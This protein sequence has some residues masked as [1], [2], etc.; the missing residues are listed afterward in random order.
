MEIVI[1]LKSYLSDLEEIESTKPPNE[2]R[3]VPTLTELADFAG[4]DVS[5]LSRSAANQRDNVNRKLYGKIIA[6]LRRRGF[7][8]DVGDVLR[9]VE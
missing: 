9:Y 6:A 7:R 8:C 1:T 5:V 3:Q 4:V 2:R